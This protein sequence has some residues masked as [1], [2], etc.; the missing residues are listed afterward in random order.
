MALQLRQ[1]V[2]WIKGARTG[3]TLGSAANSHHVPMFGSQKLQ[4][5]KRYW[6]FFE[7]P[8]EEATG[9]GVIRRHRLSHEHM[10][11]GVL[12]CL[13]AAHG[14]LIEELCFQERIEHMVS[15]AAGEELEVDRFELMKDALLIERAVEAQGVSL[16]LIHI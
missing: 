3:L 1:E 15:E 11:A 10:E 9:V 6:A 13:H 2:E 12:P 7:I 5:G 16:S 14:L 4:S 8:S